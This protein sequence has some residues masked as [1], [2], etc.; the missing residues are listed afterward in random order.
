MKD[1][2]PAAVTGGV[3]TAAGGWG[4]PLLKRLTAIKLGVEVMEPA[5]EAK[6]AE[7][8]AGNGDFDEFIKT[9]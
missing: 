7:V 4:E 9:Y 6:F 5:D 1:D 8:L 3:A 2:I